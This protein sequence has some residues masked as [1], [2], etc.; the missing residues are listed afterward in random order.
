MS[1]SSQSTVNDDSQYGYTIVFSSN[2]DWDSNHN[3]EIRMEYKVSNNANTQGGE[4]DTANPSW[5]NAVVGG[6]HY[7]FPF[8]ITVHNFE[9]SGYLIS[10]VYN[11]NNPGT[12]LSSIQWGYGLKNGVTT[13][14]IFT[15]GG[16]TSTPDQFWS[17]WLEQTGYYASL[18]PST[19]VPHGQYLQYKLELSS[20]DTSFTP[21]FDNVLIYYN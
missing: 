12:T 16:A 8:N 4:K 21:Y 11:T 18:N 5:H 17:S 19:P 9:D 15:R 20:T 1:G 7:D 10:N 13:I 2:A 14:K 6:Q 3:N